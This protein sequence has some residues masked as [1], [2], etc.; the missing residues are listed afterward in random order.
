M[1][2][3]TQFQERCSYL[4]LDI[5]LLIASK[6]SVNGSVAVDSIVLKIESNPI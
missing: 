1:G 4:S 5:C 6:N 2:S 3:N